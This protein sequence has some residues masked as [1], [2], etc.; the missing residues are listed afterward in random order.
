[1]SGLRNS[2]NSYGLPVQFLHWGTALAIFVAFGLGWTMDELPKGGDLR[3]AVFALHKSLGVLVLMLLSLRVLWRLFERQPDQPAAM[4]P[5]Q[6]KAALAVHFGL[7]ALMLAV[8]LAGLLMSNAGDRP[9]LFFGL[10]EVPR[11]IAPD[12]GLKKV[13]EEAHEVLAAF[14]I[15]LIGLH[16]LAALWH[17]YVARD[18]LIGRMLPSK[19]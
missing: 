2:P 15:T 11:M 14:M 10:F 9:T 7:Y 19:A 1:M 3:S 18:G 17:Q 4:A 12:K 16:V 8:P 13:F 5:W 6:N